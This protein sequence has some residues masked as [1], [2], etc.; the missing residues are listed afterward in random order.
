MKVVHVSVKPAQNSSRRWSTEERAAGPIIMGGQGRPWLERTFET[1]FS[2]SLPAGEPS[3]LVVG[4]GCGARRYWGNL[5]SYS[6]SVMEVSSM[7]L[8]TAQEMASS[9]AF[10]F[11]SRPVQSFCA[12]TP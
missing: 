5:Y 2:E 3:V 7:T 6:A 8:P 10:T 4:G 9:M 11:G 12:S 1:G